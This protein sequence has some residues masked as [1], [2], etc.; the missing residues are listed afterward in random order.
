MQ[1]LQQHSREIIYSLRDTIWVLNKEN[2]TITGISDRIKSYI[3]K[4]RPSYEHINIEVAENIENNVR[5][6][7]Q[8]ALNIF[9][10]VQEAVHN[11]FRHSNA[12]NILVQIESGQ[13][14]SM[15][16]KD[17]GSGITNEPGSDSNGLRNM[18]ARA[19][20]AGI[21]FSV[22][23]FAGAGTSILLETTTN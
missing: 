13:N 2:I 6:G 3:N 19:A 16:I 15:V 4:L 22:Q 8:K 7:S 9:R 1:N 18:K 21:K 10:I 12:K 11:A 20:D 14:I 5:V 23:S 17:D